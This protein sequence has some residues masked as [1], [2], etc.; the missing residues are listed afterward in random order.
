MS[1]VTR[2]ATA[3]TTPRW[4]GPLALAGVAG[5]A[6]YVSS[7]LVAG[8]WRAGYDPL[9][10]AISELF[11]QG[12]PGG[13]R[14]LVVTGLVVSA[15]ALVAFGPVLHRGLPGTS[16]LG[17]VLASV[18][19]V[20]TLGAVAFPCSSGCPGFGASSTDSWHVVAAG[21]GYVALMLAPIA[22]GWR[23]REHLG[24]LARLSFVLGGLAL[25]GLVVRNAGWDVHGGLQQR[26]FNTVAD[27][28][29]V[30]VGLVV[31]RRVRDPGHA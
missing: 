26:V 29:Y 9:S 13:P 11:E 7:W 6:L 4:V 3:P 12:A 2:R 23:V 17:P 8:W 14:A 5:V 1:A 10:Q 18:S 19:G 28:W 21:G 31:A 24:G 16:P 30:V 27:A 22:T 15:F 25:V 20:L